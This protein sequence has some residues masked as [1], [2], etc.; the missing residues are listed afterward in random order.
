MAA[1]AGEMVDGKYT[2]YDG[3]SGGHLVLFNLLDGFLGLDTFLDE[4]FANYIPVSQRRLIASVKKHAFRD[5]AKWDVELGA[6]LDR[7]VKQ[8]RVCFFGNIWN[9]YLSSLYR[10]SGVLI[11]SARVDICVSIDRNGW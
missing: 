7:I 9:R 1:A 8:L 5:E 11:E 3:L 2:E 10:L 4:G 6:Q